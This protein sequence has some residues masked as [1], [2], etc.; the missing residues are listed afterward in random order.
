MSDMQIRIFGWY[1]LQGEDELG[2]K[3]VQWLWKTTGNNWRN[4]L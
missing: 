4:R 2:K 3:P 1:W